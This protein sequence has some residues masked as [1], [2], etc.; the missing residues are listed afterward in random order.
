MK[1]LREYS[2]FPSVFFRTPL[3]P[4]NFC[5]N[6]DHL[7]DVF[8]EGLYIASPD[9]FQEVLKKKTEEKIDISLEKY[10]S[11]TRTRP[12]PCWLF[13]RKYKWHTHAYTISSRKQLST[14]YQA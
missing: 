1:K 10:C 13:N 2:F 8:L 7:E 5:F 9:L 3:Y 6:K 4:Y 12:T 14:N 11:R